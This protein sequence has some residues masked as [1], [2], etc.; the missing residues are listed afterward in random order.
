MRI[1]VAFLLL[2]VVGHSQSAICRERVDESVDQESHTLRNTALGIIVVVLIV[3][4]GY[5]AGRGL[6][7]GI[8]NIVKADAAHDGVEVVQDAVH[9][10]PESGVPH[11]A[12]SPTWTDP[13]ISDG[14]TYATALGDGACRE[15]AAKKGLIMPEPVSH[16]MI[17]PPVMPQNTVQETPEERETTLADHIAA[18]LTNGIDAAL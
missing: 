5:R 2:L 8:S 18:A 11:D 6:W 9:D 15:V 10:V 7:R 1:R 12:V 14:V 13:G 16:A 17:I 3:R 4:Q